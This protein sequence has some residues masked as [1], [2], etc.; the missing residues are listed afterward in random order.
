MEKFQIRN[1][2][3]ISKLNKFI[4]DN[5]N[6]IHL[7]LVSPE[8]YEWLKLFDGCNIKTDDI[9]YFKGKLVK[10]IDYFPAGGINFVMKDNYIKFQLPC[11]CNLYKDEQHLHP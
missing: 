11:I 7:I 4:N 9:L 5:I 8:M 6:N 3:N 10:I 1:N 2:E